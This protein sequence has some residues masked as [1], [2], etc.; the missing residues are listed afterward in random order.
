MAFWEL[1]EPYSFLSHF[2]NF[3]GK[4]PGTP[5]G[6]GGEPRETVGNWIEVVVTS[7]NKV[8]KVAK[9]QHHLVKCSKLQ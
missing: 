1:S 8:V 3:V 4:D 7:S 9:Q 5:R 6:G 2:L